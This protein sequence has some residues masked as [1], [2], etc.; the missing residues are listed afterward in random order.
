MSPVEVQRVIWL[1]HVLAQKD[2]LE[3]NLMPITT[4]LAFCPKP[5]KIQEQQL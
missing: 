3:A 5:R 4:S 1:H 2:L